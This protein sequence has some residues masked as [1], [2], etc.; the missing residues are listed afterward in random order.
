MYGGAIYAHLES[1]YRDREVIPGQMVFPYPF[2]VKGASALFDTEIDGIE[3]NGEDA[4][5]GCK[6][7]DDLIIKRRYASGDCDVTLYYFDK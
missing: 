2:T 4:I 1:I 5:A 6:V 7:F 3:D